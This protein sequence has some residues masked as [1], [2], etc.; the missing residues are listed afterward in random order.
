MLSLNY[1]PQTGTLKGFL[2][3]DA[4]TFYNSPTNIN[5]RFTLK[6]FDDQTIHQVIARFKGPVANSSYRQFLS[7][8]KA[9]QKVVIDYE[10]APT[11]RSKYARKV[12]ICH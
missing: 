6:T 1:T 2:L 3:Q 8:T 9:G 10:Q 5:V 11:G 4:Q 7:R 12:H